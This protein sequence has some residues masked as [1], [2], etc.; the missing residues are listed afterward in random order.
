M[1]LVMAF[2]PA[3]ENMREHPKRKE[4]CGQVLLR[5][6]SAHQNIFIVIIREEKGGGDKGKS[7]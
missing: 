4:K 7:I 6:K 3:T 2:V 5:V 1:L